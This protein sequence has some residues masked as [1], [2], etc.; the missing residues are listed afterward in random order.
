M[1]L[2]R[3]SLFVPCV[4]VAVAAAVHTGPAHGQQAQ[5]TAS[6]Q[7]AQTQAEA[8]GDLLTEIVVTAQRRAENLEEVPVAVTA[9]SDK[10]RELLGIESVQDMS[11]YTPSLSYSTSL[12]R[13]TLRGIGRLTNNAG[14][15]PSIASYIDG[16]YL[17]SATQVGLSDLFTER[18]DILRGPEG[19]LYGRNAIGGAITTFS[20]RPTDDWSGEVRSTLANYGRLVEEGTISGPIAGGWKFRVTGDY[21][22]QDRGYYKN[23][24][25]A[26]SE[27]G[28]QHDH[29]LDV[30][31]QGAVGPVDVWL[32][33][34]TYQLN[35]DD[36]LG[37]SRAPYDTTIFFPTGVL[38]PNPTY[39]YTVPN[40]SVA[41]P[42]VINTDQRAVDN[43]YGADLVI[44]HL[45]WHTGPLDVNYIGGYYHYALTV[46]QDLDNSSNVSYTAPP[47]AAPNTTV[48]SPQIFNYEE[49]H[50]YY[51]NELNL[52]STLNGP[53]SW[54]AG[55]YQYD[56]NLYE[57]FEITDPL[58]T[59]VKTPAATI[60]P[61]APFV[62]LGAA[63]NPQAAVYLET[64]RLH[65]QS[66][67]AFGQADY[68][69]GE[70]WKAT[71]GLRYNRDEKLGVAIQ[72][73]IQWNP[74]VSPFALDVTPVVDVGFNPAT[75]AV[76]TV[77]QTTRGASGTAQL[78]WTPMHDSLVYA[79]YDR[80][81]KAGSL[82][83]GQVSLIPSTT[84]V[85][86]E[87]LDA[88]ELG[89]KQQFGELQ[90][91]LGQL[92][93]NSD[94]F[95]YNYEDAQVPLQ[96]AGT[97]TQF[98]TQ[99]VNIGKSRT[100][101]FELESIW[102]PTSQLTFVANYSYLNTKIID[103]LCFEDPLDPT[104]TYPG[105]KP[106]AGG[107]PGAQSP[108]GS[109]LPASPPHK[110]YA[111]LTYRFDFALG[112]LSASV[113]TTYRS[114]QYSFILSRPYYQ[115]PSYDVL[116]ARL[117]WSDPDDRYNLIAYIANATDKLAAEYVAPTANA[118]GGF[119]RVFAYLPPRTY[120]VEVQYRFG[121]THR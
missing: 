46:L 59:Q 36:R 63:P 20:R 109:H 110:I 118:T 71:A 52:T 64:G 49:F 117:V 32:K 115:T 85:K 111:D 47:P 62:S 79:K 93:V 76:M 116:G 13:M 66:V 23:I 67:A 90:Q 38:V 19:T 40:P 78:S 45:T 95:Y 69:F 87:T 25:P 41:N 89:V 57:P 96:V 106:C 17:T 48:F 104:A 60:L 70:H 43:W 84:V 74:A 81:F 26:G 44:G 68:K 42:R 55:V 73:F 31:L 1:T 105:A 77:F 27:G 50:H 22:Q 4:A 28:T 92:Q 119:D 10:T 33:F 3:S 80:G 114:P 108:V 53:F 83:L 39:G 15:E 34:F 121:Q 54:I 103:S 94:V 16:F 107:A 18:V 56:E 35:F 5:Q 8:Q 7:P 98:I 58:Q 24:G 100:I 30:Q 101:G 9:L 82:N 72:R 75:P 2:R 12:D 91:P 120:G 97:G 14:T 61:T 37:L 102:Q 11:D 113:N 51:S 112:S 29:H 65:V 6:A 21:I 99:F 86:P 88:F